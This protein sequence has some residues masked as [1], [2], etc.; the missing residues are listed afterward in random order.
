MKQKN[1]VESAVK[2]YV[3]MYDCTSLIC[4]CVKLTSNEHIEE[5]LSAQDNTDTPG[6]LVTSFL[7]NF[8]KNI[9]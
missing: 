1:T 9:C 3:K 7:L 6:K 5:L 2:I 8:L 4:E